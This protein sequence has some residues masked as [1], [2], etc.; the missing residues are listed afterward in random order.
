MKGPDPRAA[1]GPKNPS[2]IVPGRLTSEDAVAGT[3]GP[4]EASSR[5]PSKLGR[6]RQ[7]PRRRTRRLLRLPSSAGARG[8]ASPSSR[9]SG[10]PGG[11]GCDPCDV[12]R[13]SPKAVWGRREGET[14]LPS[15]RCK[16]RIVHPRARGAC[17]DSGRTQEAGPAARTP[18]PALPPPR[19][20]QHQVGN[21]SQAGRKAPAG[22]A[23]AHQLQQV[24]R[25][26]YGITRTGLSSESTQV[27][28]TIQLG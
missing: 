2:P 23:G 5:R 3:A 7:D 15:P 28:P 26:L 14:N 18:V 9:D 11:G 24:V 22:S 21:H 12:E 20:A 16:T 17:A 27:L 19:G 10:D 8:G 4:L 25:I 6:W 13:S 1:P